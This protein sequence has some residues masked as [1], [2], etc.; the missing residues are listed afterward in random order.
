[1]KLA[2]FETNKLRICLN[3]ELLVFLIFAV[4]DVL[5]DF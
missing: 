2:I 1:M 5:V 4:E 3:G